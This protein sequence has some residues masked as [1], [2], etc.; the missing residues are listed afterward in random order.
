MRA[1]RT[2]P[3]PL[4][5]MP[6]HRRLKRQAYPLASVVAVLPRITCGSER[7]LAGRR[8]QHEG[9]VSWFS[10]AQI[11]ELRKR[12]LFRPIDH[13][14]LKKYREPDPGT[15]YFEAEMIAGGPDGEVDIVQTDGATSNPAP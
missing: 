11:H 3:D 9:G 8:E 4:T 2:T 13:L 15:A 1:S 5:T 7:T 6:V 14:I 12:G 10:I